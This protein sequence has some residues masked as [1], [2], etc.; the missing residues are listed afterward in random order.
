MTEGI[1]WIILTKYILPLI[2]IGFGILA[3]F[4]IIFGICVA[5]KS[6]KDWMD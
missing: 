4:L 1:L 2:L 5:I 3:I 6:I